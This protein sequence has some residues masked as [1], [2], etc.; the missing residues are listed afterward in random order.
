MTTTSTNRARPPIDPRIQERRRDVRRH[1]GRRRLR[2]LGALVAVGAIAAAG[3][4]VVFSP[5]LDVDRVL[6]RGAVRTDLDQVAPAAG[7]EVGEPMALVPESRAAAG[8]ERLP[9]VARASV[10]RSWPATVVVSLEER[11]PVAVVAAQD[12]RHVLVDGE[13]RQLEM[14]PN[15]EAAGLPVVEGLDIEPTPG[16]TAGERAEGALELSAGLLAAFPDGAVVVQVDEHG[17]LE[18]LLTPASTPE[19][20]VLVGA[21]HRLPDKLLALASVLEQAGDEPPPSIVDVRAPDAPAL[22][23]ASP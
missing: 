22:T 21:P 14:V 12:G 5:V 8:V 18:A 15:A 10:R 6:V 3:A 23:R 9:W 17:G 19:V 7:I 11:T 13:G 2:R 1:E 16:G 20:Q 4:L